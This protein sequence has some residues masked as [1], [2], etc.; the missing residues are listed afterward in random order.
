MVDWNKG[1]EGE[2][3]RGGVLGGIDDD[4]GKGDGLGGGGNGRKENEEKNIG[5]DCSYIDIW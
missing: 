2:E 1:R 4:C 3:R 5:N